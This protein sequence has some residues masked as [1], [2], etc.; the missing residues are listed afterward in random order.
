MH[1]CSAVSYSFGAYQA[2]LSK[3]FSSQ[4]YWSKLPCP[5]PADLPDPGIERAS[6]MSPAL[7]G[8]SCT[9]STTWEA[10]IRLHNKSVWQ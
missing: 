6:L 8:R 4:E 5:P 10:Q 7:T 3:G 1:A 2:P 9:T